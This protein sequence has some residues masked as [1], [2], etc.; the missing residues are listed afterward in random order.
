MTAVDMTIE[1]LRQ[2]SLSNY[3]AKLYIALL[4]LDGGTVERLS[5][6]ADVPR[7]KAYS[8][9]VSLEIK[10]WAHSSTSRP[11]KYFPVEPSSAIEN[12]I[13]RIGQLSH[14]LE[15]ELYDIYSSKSASRYASIII[16]QRQI[17]SKMLM[18]VRSATENLSLFFQSDM[19]N[20]F[21]FLTEA[22]LESQRRSVSVSLSI[23]RPTK[24]VINFFG[25][26]EV[27]ISPL[28]YKLNG[29]IIDGTDIIYLINSPLRDT[30]SWTALYIH[31][32][33]IVKLLSDVI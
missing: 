15:M 32:D 19:E 18:L 27:L 25:V 9:L 33:D 4:K 10:G 17:E 29:L 2:L 24:E 22:V 28:K 5:S 7:T 11:I 23:Y 20:N 1:K 13:H 31:G 6:E 3:E 14:S 30:A 8:S 26:F 16:G 12:A 21:R